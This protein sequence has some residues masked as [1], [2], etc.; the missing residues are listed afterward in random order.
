MHF[1]GFYKKM[2]HNDKCR[3][4]GGIIAMG[5]WWHGNCSALNEQVYF[6]H[7]KIHSN[8]HLHRQ[9]IESSFAIVMT[10]LV[11]HTTT[12]GINL[13]GK[14]IHKIVIDFA[15][16]NDFD[17][18]TKRA[19][20]VRKLI[21]VKAIAGENHTLWQYWQTGISMKFCFLFAYA[22]TGNLE[23]M[24][25]SQG[26]RRVWKMKYPICHKL[27][28]RI[29]LFKEILWKTPGANNWHNQ[30]GEFINLEYETPLSGSQIHY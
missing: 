14:G 6:Q 20:A 16:I 2:F 7:D 29:T 4:K 30:I 10:C 8:Y 15:S 25:C 9:P 13:L 27:H 17:L 12:K 18:A 23:E 21:R 3:E 28:M 19:V 24:S 26:W 22:D 11:S 1:H 5:R